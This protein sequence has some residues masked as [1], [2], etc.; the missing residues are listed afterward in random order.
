MPKE[1][2]ITYLSKD[3]IEGF[4]RA[5]PTENLRDRLLFDLIYRHGLRRQEAAYLR[6]EC[7]REGKRIWIFRLKGGVAGEYPLHPSSQ[8]LVK[9]YRQDRHNHR[10][11]FLITSRQSS[12]A[13]PIDAKTIFLLTG[14]PFDSTT[15]KG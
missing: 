2:R 6:I 9:Q 4:F 8:E 13:D 1:R 10:S 15:P 3:E 12:D 14:Y 11:P 7:I 5:I